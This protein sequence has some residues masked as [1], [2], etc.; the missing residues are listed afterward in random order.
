[1]IE[2]AGF[3]E[4]VWMN[5]DGLPH[6]DRLRLVERL[7][8]VNFETLEYEV[9]VEDS[10][11][12]TAPWT[13]GYTLGWVEGAELFEYVCQANNLSPESMGGEGLASTIAP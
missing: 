9:T 2:S 8:R 4:G 6:T 13:S 10:G 5:R 11:A 1:V 12:Y 7:T 3:S